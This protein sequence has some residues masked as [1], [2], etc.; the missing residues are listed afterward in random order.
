MT[1][2]YELY[3]KDSP[4]TSVEAA[5]SIEPN[6][7]E[8]LVLDSIKSFYNGCISDEVIIHMRAYNGIDRYSTIT[9]RYAALYRKGLIDYTGEKRKGASGRNQRVMIATERQGRL[10]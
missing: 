2:S 10:L 1:E 8:S 5:E 4:S 9:A 7:L 6:K 3:R